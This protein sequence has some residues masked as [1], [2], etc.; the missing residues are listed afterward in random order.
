MVELL[1]L[2][3][4]SLLTLLALLRLIEDE[5]LRTAIKVLLL[6]LFDAI[7]CHLGFDVLAFALA[8][9]HV[10]LKHLHK[11][12]HVF[13]V[14]LLVERFIVGFHVVVVDSYLPLVCSGYFYY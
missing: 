13:G 1:I 11:V 3:D 14:W 9:I 12:L 4:V 7:L 8:S 10:V 5:L 6:Q 2:P